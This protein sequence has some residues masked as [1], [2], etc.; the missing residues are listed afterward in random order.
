MFLALGD[1]VMIF[2]FL[3]ELRT[4]YLEKLMTGW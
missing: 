3:K 2:K 1:N 4:D